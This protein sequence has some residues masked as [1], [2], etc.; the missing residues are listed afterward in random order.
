MR[1]FRGQ[2]VIEGGIFRGCVMNQKLLSDLDLG[3][4]GDLRS[5]LRGR[6]TPKI[7]KLRVYTA[8]ATVA[9]VLLKV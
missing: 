1:Y 4:M 5:D 9:E 2:K 6:P 8:E 7:E 3:G